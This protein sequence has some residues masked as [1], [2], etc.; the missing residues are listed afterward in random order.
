MTD[1]SESESESEEPCNRQAIRERETVILAVKAIA[2]T[3]LENRGKTSAKCNH[4]WLTAF[5]KCSNSNLI[6]HT[7]GQV[8]FMNNNNHKTA[9]ET[10]PNTEKL[11]YLC[12][13]GA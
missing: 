3:L 2:E 8:K 1:Q 12:Y 11:I 6:K 13:F 9:E 5:I 7:D 10:A 4:S